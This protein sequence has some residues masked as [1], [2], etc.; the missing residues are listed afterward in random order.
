MKAFLGAVI[1]A[2]LVMGGV[3]GTA[4]ADATP[5][6]GPYDDPGTASVV[7]RVPGSD[8]VWAIGGLSYEGWF[9]GKPAL[10]SYDGAEWT[11][12]RPDWIPDEYSYFTALGMAADNLGWA[13]FY[14]GSE[15]GESIAQWDG[16]RWIRTVPAWLD[17]DSRLTDIHATG[18]DNAWLVGYRWVDGD[19]EPLLRRWDGAA[20][21]EVEP[22]AGVPV[23]S[24]LA[25]LGAD[26]T[27]LLG[28]DDADREMVWR[29]GSG[30][31]WTA[32]P[33][34]PEDLYVTGGITAGGTD[35]VRVVG[36][37]PRPVRA[38]T[39]HWNG[40]TWTT[41][42]QQVDVALTWAAF[43]ATAGGQ[44]WLAGYKV[45]FTYLPR[46]F[47]L[48]NG[49]WGDVGAPADLCGAGGR[50]RLWD[51][52]AAAATDVLVSGQCVHRRKPGRA[53]DLSYGFVARYDGQ[54]W[55]R[56]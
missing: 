55:T 34:P 13:L 8:E 6:A 54:S 25:T 5:S 31:G 47:R 35:E 43:D 41:Y 20:W 32:L 21:A 51:V 19:T 44:L 9:S 30:G 15:Q 18:P 45:K 42:D 28:R 17:E 11:S 10:V 24:G 36:S 22:P 40:A 27:W 53:D 37:T 3:P 29:W 1:A 12:Y 16:S 56:I 4:S 50:L 2:G 49:A 33:A 23:V 14:G 26:H 38:V 7:S 52:D 48:E 46:V 39:M